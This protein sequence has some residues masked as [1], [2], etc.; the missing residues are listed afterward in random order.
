MGKRE[1][2]YLSDA[3]LTVLPT[4][5]R[6]K[7]SYAYDEAQRASRDL[8]DTVLAQL[9]AKLISDGVAIRALILIGNGW[10]VERRTARFLKALSG[11]TKRGSEKRAASLLAYTGLLLPVL[12]FAFRAI[13][14][15]QISS[16]ELITVFLLGFS[17]LCLSALTRIWLYKEETRRYRSA[18][19][20]RR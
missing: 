14:G 7:L 15:L 18:M 5:P 16:R 6:T 17:M 3:Q 12:G 11:I 8:A 20:W 9:N 1:Y 19:H 2:F 10:R 4:G 13:P